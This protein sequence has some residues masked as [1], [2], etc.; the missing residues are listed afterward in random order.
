MIQIY[1]QRMGGFWYAAA[2]KDDKVL[3]TSFASTEETVLRHMLDGLPFNVPFQ[4]EDK[5]SQLAEKLLTTLKCIMAGE[6]VSLDFELEMSHLPK[7]AQRVLG[8]LVKVPV[9]YV[10]TYGALAKAAGGGARAV[11]NVMA[12]NPFAPLVPCHRVV[13]SDFDIGGYGGGYGEGRKVKRA[14]LER[15]DR[16]YNEPT[17]MK[18]NGS[19]L[20]VFPVGFVRK[21]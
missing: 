7:Y 16:G 9:G 14:I 1:R 4:V 2:M 3:A 10:T 15:E 19:V 6:D 12:S 5:R 11:G 20:S 13:R 18:V 8:F 17:E 21:D